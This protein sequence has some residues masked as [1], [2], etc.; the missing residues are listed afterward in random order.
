M[1]GAAD[2]APAYVAAL[3]AL[4]EQGAEILICVAGSD[5]GASYCPSDNLLINQADFG[6]DRE[7]TDV[8][9]CAVEPPA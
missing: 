4:A 9:T 7:M 3:R 5:D 1:N 8:E 2:A 6:R